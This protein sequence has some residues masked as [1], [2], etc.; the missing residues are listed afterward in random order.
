MFLIFCYLGLIQGNINICIYHK[1]NFC[2]C[3]PTVK[4]TILTGKYNI[5][6][7]NDINTILCDFKIIFVFFLW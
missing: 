2:N 5:E 3:F 4:K 6:N 7:N 1:A